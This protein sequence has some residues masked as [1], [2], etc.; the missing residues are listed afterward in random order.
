MTQMAFEWNRTS[1]L[2]PGTLSDAIFPQHSFNHKRHFN[3]TE[4]LGIDLE[5]AA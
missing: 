5:L 1:D 3:E 2:S 4:A